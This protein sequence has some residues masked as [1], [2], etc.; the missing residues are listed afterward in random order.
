MGDQ[1]QREE[2]STSSPQGGTAQGETQ[3]A[4]SNAMR[5]QLR[6]MSYSSG[7]DMLRPRGDAA[8]VQR[9]GPPGG[10]PA[11]PE[12][13]VEE[14]QSEERPDERQPGG[15]GGG[16]DWT[17]GSGDRERRGS[18]REAG[19]EQKEE[20]ERGT[21]DAQE[22]VDVE[23][24]EGEVAGEL[25]T[26]AEQGEQESRPAE[27]GAHELGRR[28]AEDGAHELG[29]RPAE[30]GAH[31]LG[32][33]PA[34]EGA[35][36]DPGSEVAPLEGASPVPAAGNV[37]VDAGAGAEESESEET[38]GGGEGGGGEVVVT[39]GDG[40]GGGEVPAG[41]GEGGGDGGEGPHE[42]ALPP[43]P[44]IVPP[45]VSG[46]LFVP[47]AIPPLFAAMPGA[48]DAHK[49]DG[50]IGTDPATGASIFTG[51]IDESV[52]EEQPEKEA[53]PVSQG[54]AQGV[55]D[56]QAAESNAK[57]AEFLAAGAARV[58]RVQAEQAAL[59]PQIEAERAALIANV[60]SAAGAARASVEGA[61]GGALELVRSEAAG[62]LADADATY[63]Q[64][65]AAI[66][67]K[68]AAARATIEADNQAA[69]ARLGEMR[70]GFAQDVAG[71]FTAG[72]ASFTA[73]GTRWGETATQQAQARAT[74]YG[75]QPLPQRSGVREFFEGADYE[76]NKRN[77]RV[78]AA[79]QVGAAYRDE[80]VRKAGEAA[81]GLGGA[82]PSVIEGANAHINTVSDAI[83]S[84]LTSTLT[85]IEQ[86]AT[87]TKE[88]A[89][90]TRDSIKQHIETAQREH[91]SQLEAARGQAQTSIDQ[92][93]AQ[94]VAAIDESAATLRVSLEAGYS[95]L[96]QNLSDIVAEAEVAAGEEP[97]PP[98]EL[99]A[100]L[101]RS[102]AAMD[103]AEQGL[104]DTVSAQRDAGFGHLRQVGDT[105]ASSLTEA[106]QTAAQQAATVG[107]NFATAMANLKGEL[108]R[109]LGEQ[110]TQFETGADTSVT[111]HKTA[112][113]SAITNLEG[114][115]A[116]A[117]Q[118]VQGNVDGY[119]ADLESDFSRTH[120]GMDATITSEAQKAADKVQPAWAKVLTFVIKVIIAVVVAVAIAALCA[121]GVGIG[122][123]L[124]GGALI[125]AAGAVA[126]YL[127]DVAS[128]QAEFS[129]SQMGIEAV[130]GAIG[131]LITAATGGIA[132]GA[133]GSFLNQGAA[134][135]FTSGITNT[136]AQFAAK[137][138][139]NIG[140][141]MVSGYVQQ[142]GA[143]IFDSK[144]PWSQVF[145][146]GQ[147]DQFVGNLGPSIIAG[148]AGTYSFK[149]SGL[150]NRM[151]GATG[152]SNRVLEHGY[153][154]TAETIGQTTKVDMA[155]PN[156]AI[157][158]S[159]TSSARRDMGTTPNVGA[160][161]T[162]DPT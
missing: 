119:V 117:K 140:I 127:V 18:E 112:C 6:A 87:A 155:D 108:R 75:S 96:G 154:A 22:R 23:A 158:E 4:S 60:E 120:A 65:V 62:A 99:A 53:V 97:P 41:G 153:A 91:V 122:L 76:L 110:Q 152:L 93:R 46:G 5:T 64:T 94:S 109:M 124:L 48:L 151:S 84:N 136:A 51:A 98:D 139:I 21:G 123:V 3:G 61:F 44:P 26:L 17:P 73:A 131:G 57:L 103:A 36:Q 15:E 161:M 8:P 59:A 121:S 35:R 133:T 49:V 1:V 70:T 111:G 63:E 102:S 80:Y 125:G 40:G 83:G 82:A 68:L 157:R 56:Q 16:G 126:S 141:N 32:R 74:A 159:A 95:Q 11:P 34:E 12:P 10:P 160:P 24:P 128:G 58:Q 77:A 162:F 38:S 90:S 135:F 39:P 114:E 37:E 13:G 19:E 106:G 145:T 116:N 149:D 88:A 146:A 79:Q 52:N 67:G 143:N 25:T 14:K 66:D 20:E 28:P 156:Q 92:Q 115:L 54:A 29:R 69:I 45:P 148:V 105:A 144:V 113:D 104:R 47:R 130:K 150:I 55:A 107:Q 33:R 118:N 71:V 137:A 85:A 27:D 72:S 142:L 100:L 50:V 2:K 9:K 138:G 132:S 101:E 134:A 86:A 43:A 129:W 42:Q 78:S 147:Y 30:E 89:A 7:A 81:S 31:E